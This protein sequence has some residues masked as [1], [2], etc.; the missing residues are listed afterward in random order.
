M[1]VGDIRS[2]G[3]RRK[4]RERIYLTPRDRRRRGPGGGGGVGVEFTCQP[5][6]KDGRAGRA[7]RARERERRLASSPRLPAIEASC[8]P[9]NSHFEEPRVST[10]T[11]DHPSCIRANS[12]FLLRVIH[13]NGSR[14]F[15]IQRACRSRFRFVSLFFSFFSSR[16][17]RIG[18][19]WSQGGKSKG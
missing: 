2:A 13:V 17:S 16:R 5:E 15:A 10:S 9:V 12:N 11:L 18:S 1:A 19:R 14:G 6:L 4:S 3:S 7:A 8:G